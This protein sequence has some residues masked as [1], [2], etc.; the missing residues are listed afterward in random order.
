[1]KILFATDG[2]PPARRAQKVLEKIGRRN[3]SEVTVIAVAGAFEGAPPLQD[4]MR[5]RVAEAEQVAEL[6]TADLRAVGFDVVSLT[7]AGSPAEEILKAID[8]YDIDLT[9]LGS[10]NRTWLGNLILGSVSTH[11][12]HSSPTSVLIVHEWLQEPVTGRA[13]VGVD[14]S[15]HSLRATELFAQF[16]DPGRCTVTT[17]SVAPNAHPVLVPHPALTPAYEPFDARLQEELIDKAGRE[18]E[19]ASRMLGDAGFETNGMTNVGSAANILLKEADSRRADLVVVGSRGM[20]PVRRTVL[21]SV[22]DNIARHAA[23][24]LVAREKDAPPLD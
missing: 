9:I 5:N 19:R 8:D 21:G 1:M 10:G 12:L 6:T 17:I 13:L 15:D 18:A 7:R 20:G 24:T 4:W 3:G 22:S 11:V 16:A 23:A 14:G 2:Q